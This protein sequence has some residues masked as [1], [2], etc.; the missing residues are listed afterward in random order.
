[1]VLAPFLRASEGHAALS[2]VS[3]ALWSALKGAPKTAGA[4]PAR[5]CTVFVTGRGEEMQHFPRVLHGFSEIVR[6]K[7]HES[8]ENQLEAAGNQPDWQLRGAPERSRGRFAAVLGASETLR[9][10]LGSL[11]GALKR[12]EG[13]SEESRGGSGA[14]AHCFCDKVEWKCSSFLVFYIVF[15]SARR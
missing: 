1:M 15:G 13:G 3:E 4:A 8:D 2:K 6:K 5:L 12:F 11:R 14:F 9:G 7:N 10:A